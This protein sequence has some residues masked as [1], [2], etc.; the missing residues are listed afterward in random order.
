MIELVAEG[1]S[2]KGIGERLVITERA[3]QKHVTSIFIKLDLSQSDDDQGCILADR[4]QAHAR[5]TLAEWTA[6]FAHWYAGGRIDGFYSCAVVLSSGA[7]IG[8][9]YRLESTERLIAV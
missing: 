3:V 6:I 1:R 2:N 4:Q 7:L 5:V 8:R 9:G